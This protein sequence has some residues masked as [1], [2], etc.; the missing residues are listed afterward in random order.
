MW[1]SEIF[2]APGR[3]QASEDSGE[4][5]RG[6]LREADRVKSREPEARNE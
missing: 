1:A 5:T 2:P 3:I 6:K 4:R